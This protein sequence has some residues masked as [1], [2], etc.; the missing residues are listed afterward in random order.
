[1]TSYCRSLILSSF[2]I[3]V[4]FIAPAHIAYLGHPHEP[5]AYESVYTLHLS[6][7]DLSPGPTARPRP[8]PRPIPRSRTTSALSSHL[9]P[10]TTIFSNELELAHERT[11]VCAGGADGGSSARPVI[12]G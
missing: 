5:N 10:P 12:Y 4:R 2:S 6:D 8:P 1:M 11:C 7:G 3:K 9:A